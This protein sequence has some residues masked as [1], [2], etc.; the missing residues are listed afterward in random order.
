MKKKKKRA[1][2]VHTHVGI[3]IREVRPG[4]FMVDAQFGGKR[5]RKCFRILAEA[6]T[7]CEIHKRK[8]QNEG[9]RAFNLSPEERNDAA[10]ALKELDGQSTLHAAALFWKK[11]NAANEGITVLG[12][13][14]AWVRYLKGEGCRESTLRERNQK[15]TRFNLLMGDRPAELVTRKDI[16]DWLDQHKLTGAT[17][18][19]YRRCL[20]AMFEYGVAE[21]LLEVNPVASIK[22]IRMDE[23]LPS[24]FNSDDVN[25]VLT[26]AA[27]HAPVMVPT[28]AVQFF[29]GLRPGEAKGLD[30]A[31]VDFREKIIRVT[32]E[33]SKVR[34]SRIIP[35]NK[36]L[37][38]WLIPYRQES[39]PIGVKTQNQFDYYMTRKPIGQDEHKGILGA[40]GVEWIQDGPRKT[41]ASMHYAAHEDA[42]KLA[43]VLGHTGGHDVLFRHYRGL[44]TKAEAKRYWALP[45]RKQA[46]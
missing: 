28:L 8:I 10:K 20:R 3:P 15:V 39:G 11:H 40:T 35:L 22:K 29:A 16:L 46:K 4:Y 24:C 41:F 12:L 13:S 44:V 34:R 33:T 31:A 45:S 32:P 21:Q 1:A 27:E 26:C 37:A 5:E 14:K 2:P 19:G 36:T 43:A 9:F 42:A 7:H 23:R 18:D 17:R 30:W 38:A 6:K 25:A